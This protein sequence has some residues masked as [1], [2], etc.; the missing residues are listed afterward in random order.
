LGVSGIGA[1]SPQLRIESPLPSSPTLTSARTSSARTSD[2]SAREQQ[3]QKKPK[4]EKK[5][6]KLTNEQNN[7]IL[8]VRMQNFIFT[9]RKLNKLI[10]WSLKLKH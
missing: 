6:E 10:P 5:E 7:Q 9:F 2:K 4:K 8:K 3:P 1:G